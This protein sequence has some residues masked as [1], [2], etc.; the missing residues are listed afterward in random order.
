MGRKGDHRG[1]GRGGG[2][3]RHKVIGGQS[4]LETCLEREREEVFEK[5]GRARDWACGFAALNSARAPCEKA[6]DRGNGGEIRYPR[7]LPALEVVRELRVRGR[8]RKVS[9]QE[10]RAQ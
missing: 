1:Q 3:A 7:L 4:R 2:L 5:K 8:V 6:H 9:I 10:S